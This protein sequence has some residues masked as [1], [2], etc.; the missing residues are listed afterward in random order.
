MRS[1][2][3]LLCLALGWGANVLVAQQQR[4]L[5]VGRS[6][7]EL[8]Q[9]L[10]ANA[11]A[12]FPDFIETTLAQF[13]HRP[14]TTQRYVCG[15]GCTL[16]NTQQLDCVTLVQ[17]VLALA[18]AR[19]RT[20]PQQTDTALLTQYITQ[21]NRI[22]YQRAD[23]CVWDNRYFYFTHALRALCAQ[24][25]LQEVSAS[26]G[27]PQATPLSYVSR[28]PGQFG[29][30]RNAARLRQVEDSLSVI[31]QSV[32][33]L[34]QW[35]RYLPF[36]QTGDVI[37]FTTRVPG[38]DVT[39]CGFVHRQGD[40]LYITHA[41]SAR[42]RVLL[43]EPLCQYLAAHPALPGFAVYRLVQTAR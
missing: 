21:L 30:I 7:Q 17:Y 37:V 22:R 29:R 26:L 36:A 3:I 15:E 31:P 40:V 13:V 25:L 5:A 38:L 42:R 6:Q 28:H 33:A 9:L 16:L 23:N 10:R 34:G 1:H 41:S 32:I 11:S 2:V 27:T 35:Q 14:Y 19:A 20:Q 12:P 39:H 18:A 24:G 4:V 8:L 43:R